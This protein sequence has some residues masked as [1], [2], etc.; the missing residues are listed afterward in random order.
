MSERRLL[1]LSVVFALVCLQPASAQAVP[2]LIDQI[3]AV[4][5]EEIVLRSEVMAQIQLM[6]MSEEIDR[7]ELTPE[8]ERQRQLAKQ[9]LKYPEV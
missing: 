2:Q 6:V 3:A 4:V 7:N 5:D 1:F 9:S 8:Q